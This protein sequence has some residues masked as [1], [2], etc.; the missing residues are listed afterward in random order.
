H[1]HDDHMSLLLDAL[2]K[3]VLIDSG[4]YG[5]TSGAYRDYLTGPTAH[6]VLTEPGVTFNKLA[7][8]SLVTAGGGPTWRWYELTDTAYGGQTSPY[9]GWVSYS[10]GQKTAAPVVTFQRS[11]TSLALFSVVVATPKGISVG[12]RVTR[13]P[14]SSTGYI[15]SVYV[16]SQQRIIKVAGNGTM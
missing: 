9:Q 10:N 1:G 3:Q 14:A 12:A 4:H 6:N 2:G 5:Y 15:V 8:T 7:S 11:G 16:G 13:D